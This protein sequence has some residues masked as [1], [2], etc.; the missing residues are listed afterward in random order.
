[1]WVFGAHALNPN[2]P[3]GHTARP[4][5]GEGRPCASLLSRALRA[6]V[7]PSVAR[8]PPASL[9]MQ[10]PSGPRRKAISS[11]CK[12]RQA[13]FPSCSPAGHCQ[14][15]C[16]SVLSCSRKTAPSPLAAAAARR[17]LATTARARHA[18]AAAPCRATRR[19]AARRR[20]R[21]TTA[22]HGCAVECLR[23]CCPLHALRAYG[24]S[25]RVR[26]PHLRSSARPRAGRRGRGRAASLGRGH[27]ASPRP[28]L[29]L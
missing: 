11:Q 4:H 19:A 12:R 21:C 10:P 15:K 16:M 5:R 3:L 9:R 6:A 20:S 24:R 1:M 29:A 18:R 26:A 23:S 7:L 8:C 14:W 22:Q 2:G 17:A 28:R 13:I 27:L 25:P